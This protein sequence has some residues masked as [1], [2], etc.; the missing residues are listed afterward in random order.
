MAEKVTSDASRAQHAVLR[1]Y[2]P[3]AMLF[4]SASIGV[5]RV[6]GTV[7]AVYRISLDERRLKRVSARLLECDDVRCWLSLDVPAKKIISL[8][9]VFDANNEQ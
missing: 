9:F 6:L 4:E 5:A 3:T 8:E 1:V 2:N 7:S